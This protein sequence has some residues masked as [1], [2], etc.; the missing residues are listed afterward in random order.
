MMLTCRLW[1]G[2]SV[3]L[4]LA[5]LGSSVSNAQ[6]V[7]RLPTTAHTQPVASAPADAQ[8]DELLELVNKAIDVTKRR[9]LTAG[10]HTPWQIVHGIL[11]MRHDFILKTPEGGEISAIDWMAS[12]VLHDGL[13]LFEVTPYGGRG[14][15]FT[16]PYAFEGHPTQFMGYMSMSDLPLDFVFKAGKDGKDKVT[17]ADIINDAKMQVKEGPEITWT[18]WALTHYLPPDAQWLNAAGEPWSIERMVQIQIRESVLTSAC[19]GTHGLFALSYARNKYIATRKP[20]RGVWLEAD[21]K[22]QRYITEARAL[23]NSD[24][25]FSAA[26]FRGAQHST[27]FATRLPANGH[28]LEWLMIALEERRLSEPW[29]RKGVASVAQDLIDNRKTPADCGPL[30]H[31]LH[32]LN[33]YNYRVNPAAGDFGRRPIARQQEA[34]EQQAENE[35]ASRTT[36]ANEGPAANDAPAEKEASELNLGRRPFGNT[37]PEI[38][39]PTRRPLPADERVIPSGAE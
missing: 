36:S 13:P 24:G 33:L 21:Q 14:H 18:L 37:P 2:S 26:Y 29:V 11:A 5:L 6:E 16:K 12:G 1:T 27:D 17:V 7:L 22:I 9:Q 28:I 31:A 30:Y 39:S 20:L 35:E 38:A 15:P 34:E 3:L 23:Q 25:S 10:V 32:A 4:A 19:G 8:R